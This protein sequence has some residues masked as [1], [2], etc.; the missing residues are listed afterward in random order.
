MTKYEFKHNREHKEI[1]CT[2]GN[3]YCKPEERVIIIIL[4]NGIIIL[5]PFI[6][7]Y[8]KWYYVLFAIFCLI[9][10]TFCIE[11][12]IFY[13]LERMEYFL[14]MIFGKK[15]IY[16]DWIRELTEY[17]NIIKYGDKLGLKL[18]KSYLNCKKVIFSSKKIED[19]LK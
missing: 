13:N 10:L 9:F 11:Y 12:N 6:I 3:L 8:A 15:S 16:K 2:K 7:C 4:I 18:R 17:E 5:L 19:I 1:W 14:Y